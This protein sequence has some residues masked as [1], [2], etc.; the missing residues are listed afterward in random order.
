M[1]QRLYKYRLYLLRTQPVFIPQNPFQK[2]C[3]HFQPIDEHPR[4]IL[5]PL[6]R[7]LNLA[8]VW[9]IHYP[10]PIIFIRTAQNGPNL[11]NLFNFIHT[12]EQR[13]PL[14]DLRKYTR[15]RPHVNGEVVSP[16]PEQLLRRLVPPRETLDLKLLIL[17]LKE[18]RRP[19]VRDLYHPLFV[20]QY[21]LRLQVPVDYLVFVEVTQALQNLKTYIDRYVIVN[22]VSLVLQKRKQIIL[23]VLQHYSH[24]RVLHLVI[25]QSYNLFHLFKGKTRPFNTF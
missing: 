24:T 9:H 5:R 4:K 22:R 1:S 7:K 21:V 3:L 20:Y 8:E 6:L 2:V 19:E 23:T 12:R 14:N 25:Q 11:K 16:A 10:P 13:V 17:L 18:S 15:E